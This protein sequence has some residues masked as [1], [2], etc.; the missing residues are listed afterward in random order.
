MSD[1]NTGQQEQPAASRFQ[2]VVEHMKGN[3]LDSALWI[4]RLLT[5]IFSIG[6]IIPLFG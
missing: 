2:A 1:T 3:M 4:S 5:I 6:Y